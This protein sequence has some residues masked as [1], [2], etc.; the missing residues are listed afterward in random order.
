[1]EDLS[2]TDA[3]QGRTIALQLHFVNLFKFCM[4]N[5]P[6]NR[7]LTKV[8]TTN[9]ESRCVHLFSFAKAS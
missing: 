7:G 3:D 5:C 2:K 4:A 6:F 8:Q 9:L 1:M